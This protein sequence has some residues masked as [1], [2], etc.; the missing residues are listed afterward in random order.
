[1]SYQTQYAK[2]HCEEALDLLIA[3]G[4]VKRKEVFKNNTLFYL[5]C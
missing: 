5:V 4:K 2:K 3:E 1:M